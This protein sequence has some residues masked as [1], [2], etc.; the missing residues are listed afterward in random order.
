MSSEL[1]GV[2]SVLAGAPGVLIYT[3]SATS[4]IA[5]GEDFYANAYGDP[6]KAAALVSQGGIVGLVTGDPGDYE[7]RFLVGSPGQAQAGERE[8]EFPLL[9]DGKL[10]VCDLGCLFDWSYEVPADEFVVVP[11]GPYTALARERAPET[12]G[13]RSI[14]IFLTSET[15]LPEYSHKGMPTFL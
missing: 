7:V 15:V 4:G 12:L 3:R 6:D 14:D 9:S 2:V 1:V 11:A 8:V 5:E 13:P 10:G